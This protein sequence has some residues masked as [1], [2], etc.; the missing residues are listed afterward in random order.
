MKNLLMQADI[1]SDLRTRE[2][3]WEAFTTEQKASITQFK[4]NYEKGFDALRENYIIGESLSGRPTPPS[5]SD[6]LNAQNK[7][8]MN[9]LG[10]AP[11]S[12]QEGQNPLEVFNMLANKVKE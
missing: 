10:I 7:K 4:A 1:I 2:A 9:E 12:I 11:T 8:L 5:N 3:S 6:I